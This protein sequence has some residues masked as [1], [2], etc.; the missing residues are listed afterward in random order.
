MS[1][2]KDLLRHSR[3]YLFANLATR[4]LAFVSIP[5]YTRLLTV[6][7]YGIVGVFMSLV[8]IATVLFTLNFDVAISR[9]YFDAKNENDFKS[10]VGSNIILTVI[11]LCIT[12][13]LFFLFLPIIS[14]V[15]SFTPILTMCLLPVA[16]YNVTNRIFEQIYNPMLQSKKFAIVS[17]IQIYL[18]F[19]LSVLFMFVLSTKKYFGYIYGN[20]LAMLILSVYLYKQIRPYCI[21]SFKRSYSKYILNYCVPYIPYT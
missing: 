18:G 14:E 5:V 20:I 9:Y 15:L 13:I 10:F 8:G 21:F 7:E 19:A 2:H 1:N 6:E 11:V 12:S 16:L 3:N 4:A 17:S